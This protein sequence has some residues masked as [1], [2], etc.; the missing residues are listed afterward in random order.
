[1][2]S[3]SWQNGEHRLPVKEPVFVK[4]AISEKIRLLAVLLDA[5]RPQPRKAML[6]DG[7][8]PG[9]EF[10]DGQRVAAAS[11]LKGEQAPPYGGDNFGLAADDPPFCPGRWQIR[12]C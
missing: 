3:K 1:M 10:V 2:A 12:N 9:E 7:E 5:G 4:S 6:V 8:L 11:L